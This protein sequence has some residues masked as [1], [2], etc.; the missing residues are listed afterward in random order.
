MHSILGCGNFAQKRGIFYASGAFPKS[1]SAWNWEL[2]L[3]RQ[4]RAFTGSTL[5]L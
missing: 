1:G 4:N 5:A 2:K 3:L